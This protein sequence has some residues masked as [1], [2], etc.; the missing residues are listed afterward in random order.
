LIR[1]K[2]APAPAV[3][4]AAAMHAIPASTAAFDADLIARYDVAG[5]RY[6]SYPPANRFRP[7]F[8]AEA[9][10]AA[11]RESNSDPIPSPLSLYLHI[12]FCLSPCFYCGCNRVINSD[13]RRMQRY[14]AQLHKEIALAARLF[15]R[16]RRVVQLHLGGGTPNLLEP[17]QLATLMAC[18]DR[19]F[20][21]Q[22][23]DSAELGIELDP[24]SVDAGYVRL[25][26]A[27]GFNR[28]SIGIQD[29]DPAVQQAVNRLQSREQSENVVAAAR[30]HGFRSVSVDLIYGLPRQTLAGFGRTL[31]EVVAL[32]PD[33]V[34]VYGYAHMPQR[35]RAQRLIAADQLPDAATRL[36]LLDLAV[37]RL[38]AAGYRHIG[39]D[40]FARP[41]D[42]LAVAQRQQ[43]LQ[44]NF[45]GYSTH[46]HCDLL[47]LGVSAISQVGDSF[48]QNAADLPGYY[49]ALDA[50]RLPR[51][52]GLA[53]DRDDCLRAD[54]I[55]Q[56][57]CHGRLDIAAFE[58]RHNIDFADYFSSALARLRSLRDD[59][60]VLI[61]QRHIRVTP[62]GRFLLRIVAMC[63][64]AAGTQ[65]QAGSRVL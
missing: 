24:R 41:E 59:G 47:G 31:A 35:F 28:V 14:L 56:L 20:L 30:A 46:A 60:V 38:D 62:R 53:L 1:I 15:D 3:H 64:D 21:L 19:H 43:R 51:V 63:F 11:A 54:A 61:D 2:A 36:A 44:R 6:T 55:Q 5:P 7:D 22:R 58:Q 25:L 4:S 37:N 18:L 48:S 10:A 39:M 32:S 65:P 40:H 9:F 23:G 29:F 16:D 45:Q 8:G 12:P 26:A 34:A 49:A 17:G 13:P 50:G 42:D 57:M 27:L 33:R 52:R